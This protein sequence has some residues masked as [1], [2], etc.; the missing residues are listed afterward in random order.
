MDVVDIAVTKLSTHWPTPGLKQG[1]QRSHSGRHAE[2]NNLN[3]ELNDTQQRLTE[4]EI[5]ASFTED[6]VDRLNEVVVRQQAQLE[7]LVRELR[8][9]KQ[10]LPGEDT[11]RVRSLRDELPP[12]Y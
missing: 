9:M 5:K 2:M 8:D 1:Q 11:V 4:L 12:H 6:L 3:N 7:M 10:Q